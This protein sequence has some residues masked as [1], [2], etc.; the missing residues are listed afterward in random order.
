VTVSAPYRVRGTL[1]RAAFGGAVL[2]S[3]V[4]LFTPA[5]GVPFAPPGVDKVVH[6]GL[7]ALLAGTGRWAGARSGPLAVLLVLYAGV[8]E[9]VQHVTPLNRTGSAADWLADVA[10]LLLGL[11]IWAGLARRGTP[12]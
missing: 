3:L 6:A 8:S 4:V 9:V 2:V 10:G 5:S 11:V 7:F 12:G 1:A